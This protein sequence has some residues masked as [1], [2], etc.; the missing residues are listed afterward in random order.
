[1]LVDDRHAATKVG[2]VSTEEVEYLL[3][4]FPMLT[5]C[6]VSLD[7]S[8]VQLDALRALTGL[9]ELSIGHAAADTPLSLAAAFGC[10]DRLRTLQLWFHGLDCG[11]D[12]ECSNTQHLQPLTALTELTRLVC[13]C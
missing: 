10:N 13:G 8:G 2:F 6:A 1:M 11:D 7:P 9:E 4:L 5:S 3:Q 12:H